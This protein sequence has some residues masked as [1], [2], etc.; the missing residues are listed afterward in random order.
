MLS[1]SARLN[2]EKQIN[3]NHPSGR[4]SSV[5][6]NIVLLDLSWSSN[7][8][9]TLPLSPRRLEKKNWVLVYCQFSP[10]S[11]W[12]PCVQIWNGRNKSYS[13]KTRLGTC[14]HT[15]SP[16]RWGWAIASQR[17]VVSAIIDAFQKLASSSK[18][19][20]QTRVAAQF[21]PVL[22]ANTE[23]FQRS[24]LLPIVRSRAQ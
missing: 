16:R 1:N 3:Q 19:V 11:E 21:H 15:L 23:F 20:L 9:H 2:P 5:Y 18:M 24:Y 12:R 4:K 10:A 22:P 17:S 7:Q 14:I 6:F 13:D 8:I